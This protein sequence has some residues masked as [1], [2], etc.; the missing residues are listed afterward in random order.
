MLCMAKKHMDEIIKVR[1]KIMRCLLRRDQYASNPTVYFALLTS[2]SLN[3]TFA[4]VMDGLLTAWSVWRSSRQLRD[5]PN[6]YHNFQPQ[7][8]DGPMQRL[9]QGNNL[10]G[11][12]A[13]VYS[14]FQTAPADKRA[15]MHSMRE[16]WRRDQFRRVSQDRPDFRGA[17]LGLNRAMTLRLLRQLETGAYNENRQLRE[18][19]LQNAAVLRLLLTGILSRGIADR[20]QLTVLVT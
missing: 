9:R 3:P 18:E 15:W 2:P 14:M 11:L 17:E 19:A 10:A 5:M 12:R 4:R 1:S 7:Q 8:K 6:R 13:S 16:N 20:N